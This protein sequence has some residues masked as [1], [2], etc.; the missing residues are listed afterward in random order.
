MGKYYGYFPFD[1]GPFDDR[2]WK[3]GVF[4]SDKPE[5][6]YRDALGKPLVTAQHSPCGSL[7]PGRW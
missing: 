6:P 3:I 2:Q 7:P 4:V 1:N 5:G